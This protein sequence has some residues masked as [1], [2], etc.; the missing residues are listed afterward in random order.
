MT[1]HKYTFKNKDLQANPITKEQMANTKLKVKDKN[2]MK[3]TQI[4]E[5]TC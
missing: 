2:D 3:R 4:R 5:E 1:L